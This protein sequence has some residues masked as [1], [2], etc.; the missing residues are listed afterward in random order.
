[1]TYTRSAYIYSLE[2]NKSWQVTDGL[3]DVVDPVFD[4]SGKYLYFFAS[5]NAGPATTGSRS[6]TKTTASR[7]PSG[8]RRCGATCRRR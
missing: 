4:K 3:S 6:R 8:W 1:M 5:T 2:Q 7:A